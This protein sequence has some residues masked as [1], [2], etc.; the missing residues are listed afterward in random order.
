[1]HQLF[2]ER[3]IFNDVMFALKECTHVM[4]Q[5]VFS[6]YVL[7]LYAYLFRVKLWFLSV[8]SWVIIDKV[9]VE[10]LIKE[11]IFFNLVDF[12]LINL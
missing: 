2:E 5:L 4:I 6:L 3:L 12:F 7:Q 9:K 8:R 10:H 11:M 1:M